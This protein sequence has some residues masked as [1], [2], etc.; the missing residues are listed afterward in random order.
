MKRE[1][2]YAFYQFT[3][4]DRSMPS[5][6]ET[7]IFRGTN[8]EVYF[9][10]YLDFCR[11]I[12]DWR[13][14]K[15]EDLNFLDLPETIYMYD[16]DGE[17]WIARISFAK[18]VKKDL[19]EDFA[20]RVGRRLIPYQGIF[21]DN[22]PKKTVTLNRGNAIEAAMRYIENYRGER[23]GYVQEPIRQGPTGVTQARYPHLEPP[24]FQQNK[25]KPQPGAT[26]SIR[27]PFIIGGE[28]RMMEEVKQEDFPTNVNQQGPT[29]TEKLEEQDALLQE[30]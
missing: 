15:R 18:H 30:Q 14:L 16:D 11:M 5:E 23:E 9:S 10:S 26:F 3:V 29:G 25:F 1:D 27:D 17:N 21:R 22:L 20:N 13:D 7:G 28:K 24:D 4:L 19:R 2:P 8:F 12:L 6:S